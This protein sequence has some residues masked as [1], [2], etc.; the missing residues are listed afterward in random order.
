[1]TEPQIFQESQSG[2]Y[3][4][5]TAGTLRAGKDNFQ[6]IVHPIA[7]NWQ[8]GGDCRLNPSE[9]GTDALT[10]SQLPAIYI[11]NTMTTQDT[12]LTSTSHTETQ[13][14]L[15]G[16]EETVERENNTQDWIVRK[17][18][19]LECERLMGWPDNYTLNGIDDTGTP[20]TIAKTSRYKICGNG[21]VAPITQWIG[22]RITETTNP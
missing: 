16:V 8:S 19:P 1:M 15:Y 4:H 22:Q 7:F 5:Q 21:I 9:T 10:V 12:A 3:L 18:T 13:E 6:G 17:L 11:P 20:I 14:H 2:T